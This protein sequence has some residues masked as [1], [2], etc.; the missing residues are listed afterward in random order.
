MKNQKKV[1]SI[2]FK[3]WHQN[4][5]ADDGTARMNRAR[6]RRCTTPVEVLLIECVHDLN[7]RLRTEGHYPIPSQLSLIAVALAHVEDTG[8]VKLAGLLGY[9]ITEDGQ[10]ALNPTRF[11]QLVTTTDRIELITPLRRCMSTVRNSPIN[12]ATLA[13]DLYYWNE[14][15]RNSWCFQYFGTEITIPEQQQT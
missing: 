11:Q 13:A 10:R 3:W 4:L 7:I 14:K 1:G 9:R 2:C 6:L 5:K 15:V 12:V 8:E